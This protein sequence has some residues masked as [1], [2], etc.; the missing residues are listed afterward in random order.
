MQLA[1]RTAS[2]EHR[3]RVGDS[4]ASTGALDWHGTTWSA[5][6]TCVATQNTGIKA[7]NLQYLQ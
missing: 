7:L 2:L 3:G 1:A 5:G 6:L 4:T